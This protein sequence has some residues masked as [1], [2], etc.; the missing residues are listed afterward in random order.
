M[1]TSLRRLVV[2]LIVPFWTFSQHELAPREDQSVVFGVVQ[3]AP[4]ATL[5][6]TQLFAS[7]I[8]DVYHSLPETKS[9]FQITYPGGGFAGFYFAFVALWA[10]L[11]AVSRHGLSL[12]A[13]AEFAL[14]AAL[15]A[16]SFI[17]LDTWLLPHVI[18]VPLLVAGV[19]LSAARL[20]AA[21]SL[22]SSAAG[23]AEAGA[24]DWK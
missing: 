24:T 19:G 17:D 21:P 15:L 3:G 20:T 22:R 18:T 6:Q 1:R 4:N 2:A 12:A 23:A 14:A 13:L 7:K 8:Y 5:E 9:T 16:L 11:V 10:A